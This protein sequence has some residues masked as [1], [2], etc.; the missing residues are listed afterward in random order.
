MA[1][2]EFGKAGKEPGLQVWR[3]ESMELTPVPA[4]LYGNFFTGDSY[5]LLRTS[6][7]TPASYKIFAWHGAEASPDE[8]GCA[9]IFMMQ[10]DDSLGQS[11]VQFTEYQGE[12]SIPFMTLFK[13][14]IKYQKGGVSSGFNHV[15]TNETNVKR[16]MHIKG[17]RQV[18]AT[19]VDFGWGS[20][21]SGDCFIVDLGKTIYLWY[22]SKGNKFERLKATELAKEIR[23]NERGG[24][25]ELEYIDDG[26]EPEEFINVLGE[27]PDLPESD[28]DD[29]CVDKRNTNKAQLYLISDATGSMK[30]TMKGEKNPF[31]QD[32]LCH[33]ECYIL[34]NGE[35]KK[36]FVWKG[37]DANKEERKAAYA[38][39]EKFIKDKNYPPNTKIVVMPD[40]AETMLFKQ[41]FFNWLDKDE[42]TGPGKAYRMG[43]IAQVKQIPFD[44]TGLHGNTTMAAH[45]GMVDD[46]SGKVQIWRVEGGEKVPVKPSTYG[47]FFGG[48]CYLVLYTYNTGGRERHI[49][50]TWQGQ[51]CSKD[52]LG[53]SAYLTV[54][55]DDSMGGVATQVRV[56]QGQEPPHLVSI[57][58]DKPLVIHLGGTCRK[59]GESETANVRLYHVRRSSTRASR[60]VEVEPTA[61][62]L[63]TNDVFVLKS[64][65]ALFM[66]KGKGATNEEMV[67]AK[68]VA[69]LLGGTAKE[70]DE[71][72]EPAGFWKALGGKKDYQTSPQLQNVVRSPR[73]F[74]CSNKTGRLIAEEVPGEAT[75]VDLAADDVMIMDTW[76]QVFVW[77][78]K[79]ANE[80][81]K[82]GSLKIAQDYLNSDPSARY[83][84]PISIIKQ[85]QEPLIFTGWFHAWDPKM[86]DQ[87]LLEQ[88]QHEKH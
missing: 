10:L 63:N 46:G 47:E 20:F 42:T 56:S 15:V 61:T 25:P 37:K 60:A 26:S 65:E 39:A 45:H 84:T 74:A 77:V 24:R 13:N 82:T 40:G 9:A 22:G 71:T 73:L 59:H 70:V 55:L 79:E 11:P 83:G 81:E 8:R 86:W 50:Y 19:E 14:G 76:A 44:A 31:Q 21:N 32:S 85:G 12:E 30:T 69:G 1:H 41:F 27:K 62:S 78:G 3:V 36:I 58:K 18:R 75:Q 68:Y 49:I 66:W 29:K 57:F 17:R 35:D 88:M 7:T 52:E 87:D 64:P 2:K 54:N 51:K 4:N 33:S 16:L 6:N 43:K 72:K 67:A 38:V 5:I 48:D 28:S 23:D 34:D 53:A 80:T